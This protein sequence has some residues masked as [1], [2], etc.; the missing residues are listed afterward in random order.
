MTAFLGG[1]IRAGISV[2]LISR[3]FSTSSVAQGKVAVV[4]GETH[5][6]LSDSL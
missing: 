2:R 6:I 3:L 1:T 4:S 5:C